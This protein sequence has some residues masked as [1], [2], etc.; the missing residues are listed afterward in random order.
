M[1]DLPALMLSATI[2][3][4]WIGVGVMIVRVRKKGTRK[5]SG[6]VP[7]QPLEQL[8]W[9]IWVPLVVAWV[10]L[11]YLAATRTQ[12][13]W[14]VS[15]FGRDPVYAAI[16]WAAAGCGV[17]CLALTIECWARM[18]KSWRMAVAPDQNTE[19]V[20]DGLYAHIRHPI[21]ALSMLLMVC[22]VVV[23]ANVPM[24]AVGA[25]HIL[26]MILKA[27]N[28]ERFLRATLGGRYERYCAGTGRFLPRFFARGS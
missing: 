18:G 15:A 13:P 4:Y 1:K 28:E 2:S 22:S 24:L 14:A 7:R 19:L 6:V 3:A 11:P 23:V 16:R 10:V 9:V 27:R 12:D 5:L 8:L 25:V 20:T 21:Y 17:L 26:L